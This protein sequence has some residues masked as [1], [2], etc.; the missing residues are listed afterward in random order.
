M[1]KDI[2]TKLLKKHI[3]TPGNL[4]ELYQFLLCIVCSDKKC[5]REK[6][7][8]STALANISEKSIAEYVVSDGGCGIF[9]IIKC[10][11]KLAGE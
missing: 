1:R 10:A 7:I 4:I 11:S 2:L 5:A 3:P 9:L 8:L 6:M